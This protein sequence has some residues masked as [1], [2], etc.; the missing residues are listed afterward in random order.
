MVGS[1]AACRCCRRRGRCSDTVGG[2][3]DDRCLN[4][5]PKSNHLSTMSATSGIGIAPDLASAFSNANLTNDVRFI[6]V[7]IANET[8]VH[9]LTI[10]VA[11]S[12][13]DDL[14]FLQRPNVLEDSTPTYVLAKV[15]PSEWIAI[16]YVPDSAKVRDKMLY[17]STRS[18]LL[19]A[20]GSTLFTDAI[21]AT[22]L[23]DLTADAYASHKR[24][25]AAPKPLSS[26]EQEM[27]DVRAAESG[28]AYEGSRTRA[29]HIGTG[30]GLHWSQN[31]DD[32]VKQLG[33]GETSALVII[34]IDTKTETL[35]VGSASEITVDQLGSSLPPSEPCYAFFAWPHT[36]ASLPRREIVFIYS[37]PSSS[38]IKDRMIYSSGVTSTYLAGQKLLLETS[39]AVHFAS[40]KI[41]TSV[42][43]E[44]DEAHLIAELGFQDG[45]IEGRKLPDISAA[46]KDGS[47]KPFARPKGPARKR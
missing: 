39:P 5:L 46:L 1:Q 40:R 35:V 7:S 26:R 20:I 30:V 15:A 10:P 2:V 43:G 44:I 6:K 28:G 18:S 22:S 11:G 33:Q 24:H 13:E 25:M 19:K 38:P 34:N 41:E 23:A 42:P 8:L 29:S 21:F 4:R 14:A 17:A 36:H 31:V 9:D 32:A 12:F 37:C 27:A 47:E 16:S 45:S 3:R